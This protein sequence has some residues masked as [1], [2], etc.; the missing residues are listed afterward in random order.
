VSEGAPLGSV[1][2]RGG[3]VPVVAAERL[4]ALVP[5][6]GIGGLERTLTALPS[7]AYPPASGS[8]VGT[9]RLTLGG[10]TL[11]TVSLLVAD[12]PPPHEPRGSWWSR[13]AGALAG[14]VQGVVHGLLG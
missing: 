5:S 11:G 14:A 3:A 12:L 1:R 10:V 13:A 8:E 7:A 6:G 4:D 2:I 9:L